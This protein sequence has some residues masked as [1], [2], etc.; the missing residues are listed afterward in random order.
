VKTVNGKE[1]EGRIMKGGNAVNTL[2]QA[3]A[4][5]RG[6]DALIESTG[7]IAKK[8]AIDT[9]AHLYKVLGACERMFTEARK[10]LGI[11]LQAWTLENAVPEIVREMETI[12]GVEIPKENTRY[13]AKTKKWKMGL[14]EFDKLNVDS[15]KKNAP[16]TYNELMRT[17]AI[18]SKVFNVNPL[19]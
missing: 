12:K 14:T 13:K 18:K 1:R 2:N 9:V 11:R 5:L 15:V 8:L 7:N 6:Q 16:A 10:P 4:L 19:I 3:E 17:H